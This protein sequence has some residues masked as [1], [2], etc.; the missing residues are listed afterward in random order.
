MAGDEQDENVAL[1]QLALAFRVPIIAGAHQTV[2]PDLD[3]ALL[4]R[5]PQIAGDERQ[6]FDLALGR[7]LRLVRMG[8]ADEDA[9]LVRLGHTARN[10]WRFKLAREFMQIKTQLCD[11]LLNSPF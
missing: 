9:G 3:R 2:D 7:R 5:R 10:R 4:D 6:P 8:V 11:A 1:A